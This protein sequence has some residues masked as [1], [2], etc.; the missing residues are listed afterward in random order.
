MLRRAET[1]RGHTLV[2]RDG[3]IGKITDLY[4]DDQSWRVRYFVVDTGNW[5]QERQVLIS[6]RRIGQVQPDREVVETTLTRAEVETCPPAE[7][8]K[9]VSEQLEMLYFP[10]HFW[11]PKYEVEQPTGA[12]VH[13][14]SME[15]VQGYTVAASDGDIG[16]VA[17][18]IVDDEDWTIRY[19]DVDTRSLW[20]SKHVLMSP[21]WIEAVDWNASRVR[22]ALRRDVIKDSPE[23]DPEIPITREY[24]TELCEH[25]HREGYW[26]R[27]GCA[28]NSR[29]A[30]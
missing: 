4:F 1:V 8:H 28:G 5:L 3:E 24:E 29:A 25:Y 18:F 17:R 11:P 21:E 2:G 30:T 7:E 19:L 15:E 14:R 12:D 23:Y 16:H 9:P 10:Y 20:P 13:L 22:V 27:D 6:P 26:T